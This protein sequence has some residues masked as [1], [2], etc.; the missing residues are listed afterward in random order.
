MYD[1]LYHALSI[2]KSKTVQYK[3]QLQVT[4]LIY[5]DM[6][7]ILKDTMPALLLVNQTHTK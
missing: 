7:E 6:S 3:L 4:I 2:L 1:Q 5:T